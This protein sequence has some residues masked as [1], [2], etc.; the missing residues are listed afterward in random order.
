MNNLP[1]IPSPDSNYRALGPVDIQSTSTP[2]SKKF[3][4]QKFLYA[5]RR[6]W[7][8]I[9]ITTPL[10]VSVAVIKF[11]TTPPVFVS[12]AHMWET[13]K[14]DL[15]VQGFSENSETYFGTLND[16]L[17]SGTMR[18]NAL[19]L[20]MASGTND[21][22]RDKS[23]NPIAVQVYVTSAPKSSVFTLQAISAN[24]AFTP[25][26]LNALMTAYREYM[27]TV[28]KQV[29]GDTLASISEQ[30]QKLERDLKTDQ[31]ALTQF[32]QT[33][34]Y[35]VLQQE[36]QVAASYLAKLR[37]ELADYELQ[38][39]LLDAVALEKGSVLPGTTNQMPGQ[40]FESLQG[41][42]ASGSPASQSQSTYQDLQMLKFQRE[43]LSKY[44][45]PEHPKIINL[46]KQIAQS[47]K[48]I[49]LYYDSNKKQIDTAKEALDIKMESVKKSIAEWEDKVSFANS[50]IAD[51]E[52]LKANV[53]RNQGIV[54]RL[55]AMLQN[56]DI[57]RSIDQSTIAVL[58]PAS[59]A[60]RSYQD[61]KSNLTMS[62]FGGFM[63]GIA[64][65]FLI[66][67]RDD[68]IISMV[69]VSEK[70]GDNVVGQVPEIGKATVDKPV[71][72]LESND[73]RH[74]LAESYRSLRSAL[75]YL[76]MG[77][78]HPKTI[79]I[80]SAIPN[81]GKS[82]VAANLA[83]TIAMGGS[84]VLLVDADMRRGE[85]HALLGL[86]L[87][88]GLTNVLRQPDLIEAAIQISSLPNLSFLSRGGGVHSPGDLLLNP[89]CDQL[90]SR[91]RE[92]FDYVIIDSCP[93][94]AADDATTLAPKV[95]GSLFV[96]RSHFSRARIVNDALDLLYQRQAKVL[97]VILNRADTTS[98]AY[99]YYNYDEYYSS[100]KAV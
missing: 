81:E 6:F 63:G 75:V 91:L 73:S 39:R 70:I 59:P 30:V 42:G 1:S 13:E 37:T 23:G 31:D 85:L 86:K 61:A 24:P 18:Q 47:Q 90:L 100:A 11:F 65:I 5:L 9:L 71:A 16:V 25:A 82:T 22:V 15:P 77:A 12:T 50:R 68:R 95:D 34:N 32:E 99:N 52:R 53:A 54:D 10:C 38:A 55:E 79:L 89:A 7:W 93:V 80:T 62:I 64:I 92:Q 78:D 76:S 58:E 74:M 36:N 44:L 98:R 49:D 33:N 21:I 27:R 43:R 28:R 94:F 19:A 48:L 56:V 41:S 14:L 88:P 17:R 8:I 57:G 67:L 96:V 3:H 2:V 69:E 20:M 83:R 84:R 87:E 46:D 51:A 29:S 72:L 97:G 26:Y 40:L 35:E 4:L 45:R 60:T 66:S